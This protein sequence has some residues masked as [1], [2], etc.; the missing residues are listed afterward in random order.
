[1]T[2]QEFFDILSANPAMVLFYLVS[3][4]VTAYVIC[5]L[6]KGEGHLDPWK[7]IHSA[8]IY[9]ACIP[10]IFALTLNV[11]LFVFERQSIMETNIYTQILPILTMF[12]TLLFISKNV[13]LKSIPGFE[14]VS[15]LMLILI[16][17]FFL[18]WG[19]EKTRIIIFSYLPIYWVFAIVIGF[20]VIIRYGTKKMLASDSV[21]TQ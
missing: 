6:S 13:P 12:F 21:S 14:K 11:Y 3:L 20:L 4:P 18:M 10:G 2:L 17:M 7:Y 1:M 16:A 8:L 15:G 9:L 5:V 19:L